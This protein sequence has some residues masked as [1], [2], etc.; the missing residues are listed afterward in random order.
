MSPVDVF[1]VEKIDQLSNGKDAIKEVR[2]HRYGE[3]TGIV[4][5]NVRNNATY[6]LIHYRSPQS[7]TGKVIIPFD[8]KSIKPVLAAIFKATDGHNWEN[9]SCY[10]KIGFDIPGFAGRGDLT[11]ENRWISDATIAIVWISE[12]NTK[13]MFIYLPQKVQQDLG[14]TTT[15]HLATGSRPAP[16]TEPGGENRA[17][18][19]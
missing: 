3:I 6:P 18:G 2:F 19:E 7:I 17:D 8:E 13:M 1:L 16:S 4:W 5:V 12:D 14:W 10:Y 15:T 9:D 11:C